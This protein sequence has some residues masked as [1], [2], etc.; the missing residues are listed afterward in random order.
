M[1]GPHVVTTDAYDFDKLADLESVTLCLNS[2]DAGSAAVTYPDAISAMMIQFRFKVNAVDLEGQWK[3]WVQ[4]RDRSGATYDLARQDA[5]VRYYSSI[6]DRPIQAF[7]DFGPGRSLLTGGEA[8]ALAVPDGVVVANAASVVTIAM[9]QPLT[10]KSLH[11]FATAMGGE[12]GT[13]VRRRTV[14]FNC[15]PGSSFE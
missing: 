13:L 1:L 3:L 6:S 4:A 5:V 8:Y 2:V 7:S 11:R 10:S 14:A 12:P 15:S 9:E